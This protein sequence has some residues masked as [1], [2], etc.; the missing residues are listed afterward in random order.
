MNRIFGSLAALIVIHCGIAAQ[1]VSGYVKGDN[2][3]AVHGATLTLHRLP[4]SAAVKFVAAASNGQYQFEGITPARYIVSASAVGFQRVFSQPFEVGEAATISLPTLQLVLNVRSMEGVTVTSKRPL[5]EQK[6]D[7]TV[8]NV[9]ASVTNVGSSA[10]DVLEKSPGVAVDKDGNISL[11]G[12]AGVIVLIDGRTTHLAGN[13]LADYLR[14]LNASQLDQ[15]E[16]M[17]NPPA[18]YDAAGNSGI[19]NIKTKKNRQLG[20]NG[21]ISGSYGQGRYPKAN[22]SFNFNYRKNKFNLFST[23]SHNYYHN[24]NRLAIQRRFR[25]RNTKEILSV[26]DQVSNM[27]AEGNSVNTKLGMDYFASRNTSFGI[28]LT[29][30]LSNRDHGNLNITDISDP[31]GALVNQTRAATGSRQTWKNFSSNFN[32]RQ[33]LDSLGSELTADADFLL[34]G[35]KNNQTMI[36]AYYN[37]NGNT[38]RKADTLL[39]NLPQQIRIYSA[40]SDFVKAISKDVRFEAG[41]KASYVK[42]DNNAQYD[43]IT[44]G[45]QVPDRNRSNH[46]LYEEN[47]NA[48]YV[49]LS[50]SLGKK[51][52]GQLGLRLENTNAR[53]NQLTSGQKF[54]RHYTQLFPTAYLQYKA[55]EKNS[56]VMN[57]GRRIR[58]P[59]YQSLNPFINFLD[60]YTYQQGNPDLRP[61][62]SHN[63]ELSHS[64][65]GVVTTTLNYSRTND[66]IQQVIEQNEDRNETYVK[67]ANIAR[68]RQLGL[69][70]NTSLA[71]TKWWK[72]NVFINAFNNRFDGMVN[73]TFVSVGA[74]TVTLN[75]SQQFSFGKSWTA[76]L[77]AFYRTAGVEGV[78]RSRPVGMVTAGFSRQLMK[79][80]GTLRLTVRDIFYTQRFRGSSRYSNIDA[81]FQENR[82]SRVMNI[83]FTYRFSKGKINGTPKRRT[84]SAVDE[85]SRISGQN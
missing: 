67:Q 64:H 72:S 42:T 81:A 3:R 24:Y 70:V 29:G 26:F 75:G 12:K 2:T 18:R 37:E 69:A 62:F 47:I 83:G 63:I 61:Q 19:I 66:I 4:D 44:Y 41:V 52:N 85:Q 11:K 68:Q 79:G 1:S 36:N 34:Y 76:E 45:Q 55:D 84:G 14:T 27:Q 13:Q 17:T 50:G 49:N 73:D 77:S 82:D 9:E 7:R 8:I 15:I 56:F 31:A 38:I 65:R 46:F 71:V 35:T 33:A 39:G 54:D 20:Y 48:A 6:V 51:W 5:V 22:E 74:T 30:Y 43:S 59:D 58:R 16:L 80:K 23:V 21:S 28:V 10:L 57:Y 53:G 40:K 25:D 32:F 60:R 78:I